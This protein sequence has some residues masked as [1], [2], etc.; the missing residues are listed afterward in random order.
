MKAEITLLLG[1]ARSGKSAWA[2]RLASSYGRTVVYLATATAGDPEMTER[3]ARHRATRPLSWRSVEE[4]LDLGGALREHGT[5]GD[6][7]VIDCLTLWVSNVILAR[8]GTTEDY[9]AVPSAVWSAIEADLLQAI[10]ALFQDASQRGLALIVVSNEV[11]MGLVP[12]Y[13]LGRHYRDLLGRVNREVAAR[14]D[15]V[16]LLVAGLPIDLRGLVP[17]ELRLLIGDDKLGLPQP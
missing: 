12:P 13:P 15:R 6:V 4:A 16:L 2:E 1:G 8:L 14:A 5:T 17:A 7:I 9:A 10:A 11:G 3:I